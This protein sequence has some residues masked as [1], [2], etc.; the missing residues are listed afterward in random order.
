MDSVDYKKLIKIYEEAYKILKGGATTSEIAFWIHQSTRDIRQLNKIL[1]RKI[2]LSIGDKNKIL[3]IIGLMK[4]TS[5]KLKK[6]QKRGTG[7]N[8]GLDRREDRIRWEDLESAFKSRIRTG[9][10]INLIHKDFNSFFED[11]KKMII[12]RVKNTLNIMGGLKV[13]TILAARFT[14]I[15][16]GQEIEEIKFFNTKNDTILKS[17]D[18]DGWF[19]TKVREQ[20]L[21]KVKEFQQKKSGWSLKEIINVNVNFNKYAPFSVGLS[22]FIQLPK[23]IQDKRAVVNVENSDEYCFLWSVMAALCPADEHLERT[24]SYP[25]FD[26]ILKYDQIQFPISLGDVPKFDKMNELRINVYGIEEDKKSKK[27]EIVPLYLSK[28]KSRC[29]TIHLL[30][31]EDFDEEDDQSNPVYHFSWIKNLSRLVKSQ[32]RKEHRH[33]WFCD[34][35]LCHFKLEKSFNNHGIDCENVNKCRAILP[36]DKDKILKLKNHRYKES[37]PFVVYADIE[38]LL[39]PVDNEQID[40]AAYQ[41]H[42][43]TSVAFYTH[44]NFDDSLSELKI[45][46]ETDCIEWFMKE[47][48]SFADKVDT[49]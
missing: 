43:S 42:V 19:E 31:I 44:C 39:E 40:M 10:V 3:S 48:K 25:D 1:R 29:P 38:S 18:L 6:F 22:T 47:L 41:K 30:I 46:R 36:K 15:E 45:Y 7:I 14:A 5:R 12:T 11:A 8:E 9:L 20:I 4:V 23:F 2:N 34:R 49:L 13:N 24:T 28:E 37:V 21:V 33:A 26:T 35:C 17:T 16:E 27:G 32:F